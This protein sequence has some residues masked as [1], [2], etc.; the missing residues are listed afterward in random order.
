MADVLAVVMAGGSGSRLA[1]L[2]DRRAKPAMPYAGVYRLIDFPLSN[3]ANSGIDDVWVVQQYQP[4][5]L[6]EHLAGGRPWDLDR[7]R[8]GLQVLFPHLGDEESGWHQGN[9][10][11]LFRNCSLI[12]QFDADVVLVLSADHIYTL[13]YRPVIATHVERGAGLTMVTT[14]QPRSEV[15][16]FGNVEVDGDGRVQRY[17][18]KPEEPLSELVTTE[19][20][21]FD[22]TTLL[23]AIDELASDGDDEALADLGEQLLPYLVDRGQ[24]WG[25][26]LPGYW[27]DVGTIGS[28]WESH[29]DLLGPEPAL[30]LD[31]PSWPILTT[32]A[33]RVPARLWASA[34]VDD[35]LVAPGCAVRG[36]VARSVLGPGVVI[37]EGAMVRSSVLLEGTV[38]AAGAVVSGAICDMGSTIGAGARVGRLDTPE[39]DGPAAEDVV[40]VGEG[41]A[42]TP[43]AEI[44]AGARLA[45]E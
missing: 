1:P 11:A 5:S 26:P 8:G 23:D 41:V 29:L 7:T 36:D 45:P 20:F 33:S 43:G 42:V 13:D 44:A 6:G 14:E 10:D 24:V 16:R 30:T 17:R 18:Y 40:V 38:V 27:R 15:G 39:V 28:Y 32:A 9:A 3:C 25:H 19:V 2:T 31:D 4:H 12:R 22:A 21:L 35:V 37:E 34:T